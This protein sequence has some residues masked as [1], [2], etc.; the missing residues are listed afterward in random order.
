MVIRSKS[1]HMIT[2]RMLA[3]YVEDMISACCPPSAGGRILE[4]L[5]NGTVGCGGSRTASA[6]DA[7]IR[8]VDRYPGMPKL[9]MRE[10]Y[11][12]AVYLAGYSTASPVYHET[13]GYC[14]DM[15]A[16]GI[17]DAHAAEALGHKTPEGARREFDSVVSKILSSNLAG[18]RK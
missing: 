3:A 6:E 17:T 12:L 15:A 8:M 9:T 4:S 2:V 18:R 16:Q 11:V 10:L 5:Q 1:G 14:V 13:D 7:L